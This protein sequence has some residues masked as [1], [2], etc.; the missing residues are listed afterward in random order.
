[1]LSMGIGGAAG[2]YSMVNAWVLDPLPYPEPKRLMF[3]CS[4]NIKTGAARL[5]APG[6]FADWQKDP[7]FEAMATWSQDGFN[8]TGG[9][10]NALSPDGDG[11]GGA[12]ASDA[13]ERLVGARV[14]AN[15]FGLLGVTPV[16]G[17]DFLA[18]E[19]Q[20]GA[21]R[22]VI[23]TYEYWQSRFLS[24]PALVGKT[25]G[26]NDEPAVVRG[27]LP[28]LFNSRCWVPRGSSRRW[29]WALRNAPIARCAG[30]M[31]WWRA[32]A[33]ECLSSGPGSPCRR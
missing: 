22:S 32:G 28:P 23:L 8:L 4:S 7:S 12:P 33:P 25:I 17:R 29:L 20:P 27:I 11:A 16:L 6:D 31:A 24:D 15:F 5:I 18:Q 14:S 30:W 13:P 2:M 1:M 9:A 26:L 3:L 21:A 19:D 10:S